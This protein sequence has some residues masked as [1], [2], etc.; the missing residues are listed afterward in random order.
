M[1]SLR[2][3]GGKV[4]KKKSSKGT[5]K[6]KVNICEKQ[7]RLVDQELGRRIKTLDLERR[8]LVSMERI[9]DRLR[10]PTGQRACPRNF[11]SDPLI[12]RVN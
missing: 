3:E 10:E 5:R 8:V 4:L 2:M 6:M 9:A 11:P 12:V 7:K 1:V